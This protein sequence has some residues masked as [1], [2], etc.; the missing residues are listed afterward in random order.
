VGDGHGPSPPAHRQSDQ[1]ANRIDGA[2]DPHRGAR[3]SSVVDAVPV[4]RAQPQAMG[5]AARNR[6]GR[7]SSG[8]DLLHRSDQNRESDHGGA[9][10]K[11]AA[12]LCR[13]A[14]VAP[15]GRASGKALLDL[16]GA[17][18]VRRLRGELRLVCSRHR[19]RE[20]IR[21]AGSRSRRPMGQ[22]HG[23]GAIRARRLIV[24]RRHGV[25]YC[26]RH[27]F[28]D[29]AKRVPRPGL[30]AKRP[31]GVVVGPDGADSRP[32]GATRLLSRLA[33]CARVASCRSRT[34]L[35]RYGRFAELDFSGH[36]RHADSI[37]RLRTAMDCDSQSE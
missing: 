14:R 31:A 23:V 37:S 6:L 22:L 19:N 13:A 27:A 9:V 12:D 20:Q 26:R 3:D 33:Q 7:L 16:S 18:I 25:A 30:R 10:A 35:C 5:S 15:A 24:L 1:R 32:A 2:S 4:A 21:A 34:Q 17:G 29:R 11:N 36:A 8:D 28:V